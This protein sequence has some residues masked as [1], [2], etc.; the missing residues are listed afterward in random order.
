MQE[1]PYTKA[2]CSFFEIEWDNG[3]GF[4]YRRW[5]REEEFG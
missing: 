1:E 3:D 2:T 5:E 4:E